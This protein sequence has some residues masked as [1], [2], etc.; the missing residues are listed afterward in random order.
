MKLH[1][2]RFV[3]ALMVLFLAVGLAFGL[4]SVEIPEK[5]KDLINFFLGAVS[6]WAGSIISHYFGDPDRSERIK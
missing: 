2:I 3:I 1:S 6:T 4:F 5:N